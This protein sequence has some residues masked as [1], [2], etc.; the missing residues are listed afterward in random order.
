MSS[1][2]SK[3]IYY[4]GLYD[5]ETCACLCCE[6][7][8]DLLGVLTYQY[9]KIDEIIVQ[10][11]IECTRFILNNHACHSEYNLRLSLHLNQHKFLV[12]Y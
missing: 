10:I 9:R 7:E 8:K 2:N 6:E 11:K 4:F 5:D 1:L 12:S 3:S